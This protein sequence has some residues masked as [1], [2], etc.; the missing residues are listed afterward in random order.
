MT[1]RRGEAADEGALLAEL[2]AL[3]DE[4]EAWLAGGG[5]LRGEERR[6]PVRPHDDGSG[7]TP[8]A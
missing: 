6:G 5:D 8:R 2:R 3:L 1:L 4:G 7:V